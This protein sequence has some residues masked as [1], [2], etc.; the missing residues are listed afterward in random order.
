MQASH[1]AA[2]ATLVWAASSLHGQVAITEVHSNASTNGTPALHADWW[3]LTNFGTAP[4]N[5]SGY[6][7][8]DATGGLAAGAVTIEA[9]TLAPGESVVFV[10]AISPDAFRQW[11][12]AALPPSLQ[13]IT[14][15][16]NGIGL[17][18]S[19]DG[20]RLWAP[21]ATSD[22]DVVDVV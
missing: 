13:V 9:L 6:R 1:W 2:L 10:E 5:L 21:G 14:Y 12:G 7:F 17:S 22:L 16:T 19:G 3:E 4:A 18:S 8:N 15:A 11:W 20:L